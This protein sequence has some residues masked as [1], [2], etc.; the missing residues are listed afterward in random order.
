MTLLKILAKKYVIDILELLNE[1]GELGY[2]DIWKTLVIDKGTLSK[3]LKE[4]EDEDLVLRREERTDRRIPR[5]Y[6]RLSPYGK[7]IVKICKQLKEAE[8]KKQEL[9]SLGNDNINIQIGES[10]NTNINIKK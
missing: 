9:I 6:Y 1:H 5:A 8:Q 4:L 7:E 2:S 10:T 3:L